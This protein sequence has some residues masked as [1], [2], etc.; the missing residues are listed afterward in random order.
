MTRFQILMAPLNVVSAQ[1]GGRELE[2]GLMPML[3]NMDA[4]HTY[5]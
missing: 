5:R 2:R 4:H 1:T 3:V